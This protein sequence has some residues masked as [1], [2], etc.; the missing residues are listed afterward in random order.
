LRSG[1]QAVIH[2]ATRSAGT[3][4]QHDCRY[5]W[6]IAIRSAPRG[7]DLEGI[8]LE[9]IRRELTVGNNFYLPIDP[10]MQAEAKE[11]VKE[12]EQKIRDAEQ[13]RINREKL[14]LKYTRWTLIAA[15]AAVVVGVIGIVLSLFLEPG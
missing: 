3:S 12:Q 8:G 1:L 7:D 5:S 10:V 15:I 4:R 14:T 9:A 6:R 11:W 2:P 13:N